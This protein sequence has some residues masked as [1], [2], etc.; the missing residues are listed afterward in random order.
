MLANWQLKASAISNAELIFKS[1]II[2]PNIRLPPP[3]AEGFEQPISNSV[4]LT[5]DYAR[6]IQSGPNPNK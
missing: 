6:A 5:V 1:P 2:T 3:V 4:A